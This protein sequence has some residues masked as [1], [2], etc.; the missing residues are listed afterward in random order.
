MI[1]KRIQILALLLIFS[2]LS[3]EACNVDLYARSFVSD[4]EIQAEQFKDKR[5][6]QK[7]SNQI[8][9]QAINLYDEGA[10]WSCARELII[11]MDFYSEFKHMDGVVHYLAECLYEEELNAAALKMYKYLIKRYPD[12]EYVPA[13]LFGLQK[14]SYKEGNY[15]DTLT[16]YYRILKKLNNESVIDA[17]RY[18]AGQSHYYLKNYD[19]AIDIFKKISSKSEYYDGALYTTALAHLKRKEVTVAM[20][21]F[22]RIV[23]LPIVSGERRRI[24]DD[25][26]LT[27][28]YI[29]YELDMFRDA[30]DLFE[31][32]SDRHVNYQDALLA[33]GWANL[34]LGDYEDVIKHLRKLIDLYPEGAN[35]E[36]SYFLLGQSHIMLGEFDEA[37]DAYQTIVELFPTKFQNVNVIK[38]V[39]MSLKEEESRIE[40][41]KVQ[42]LIQESNLLITL[43]LNGYSDEV[44]EYLI[45]E[46]KRLEDF[47]TNL[48]KNLIAER[49]NFALMKS[50][51][52]NLKN[53][54]ARKERR[55]DW[56]G[57][58]EYGIS[59]A[60]FLKEMEQDLN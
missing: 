14:T 22:K 50:Q 44:P 8:Y 51:I 35:T 21:Y 59:R 48:V 34:K 37:I 28:G 54:A 32:I 9:R 33:L 53:V 19:T 58:A 7:A 55:K 20:S 4:D 52:E 40:Q 27:L 41:L 5:D 49:N 43:P 30:R 18:F 57:Y 31:D 23:G 46:K 26:R 15:K 1:F 38:K 39:S 45:K 13:A 2:F 42:V 60:L 10:Y 12:S 17:A 36:E 47:R 11:L 6:I 56:R 25:A 29:Y 24:V 3:G 16:I